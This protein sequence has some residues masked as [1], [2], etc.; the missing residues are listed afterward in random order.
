MNT[1][2]TAAGFIRAAFDI[3]ADASFPALNPNKYLTD[4][5]LDSYLCRTTGKLIAASCRSFSRS[6]AGKFVKFATSNFLSAYNAW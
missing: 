5:S 2:S 6:A 3:P 1:A 4:P